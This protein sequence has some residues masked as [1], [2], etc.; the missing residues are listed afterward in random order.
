V[1][2]LTAINEGGAK[3]LGAYAKAN[4]IGS[5]KLSAIIC[6]LARRGYIT[7]NKGL[8]SAKYEMTAAGVEVLKSI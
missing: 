7:D 1:P 5:L 2:V 4:K 8:N 3:A 6:H